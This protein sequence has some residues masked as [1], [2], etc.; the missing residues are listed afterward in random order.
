M[1]TLRITLLLAASLSLAHADRTRTTRGEVDRSTGQGAWRTEHRGE[2]RQA[3]TV[4]Q[5]QRAEQERRWSSTT[6][7]TRRN[8]KTVT[9]QTEGVATRT[10]DYEG[11]PV[12][13]REWTRTCENGHVVTGRSETRVEKTENGRSWTST[14][15]RSGPRGTQEF[16]GSGSAVRTE[17]GSTWQATRQGSGPEGRGWTEQAQGSSTRTETG[18]TFERTATRQH[19]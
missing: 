3:E 4:G 14:G 11:N 10:T 13:Q 8:G 5:S 19:R 7:A 15:S 6:T 1:H 2:G 9:T 17:N 12:I 16:T 18:R